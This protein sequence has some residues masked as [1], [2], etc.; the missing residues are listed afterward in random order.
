M[1][2]DST[3]QLC[4][5][6]LAIILGVVPLAI[7]LQIDA[8]EEA[9]LVRRLIDPRNRRST[10]VNLTAEGSTVRKQLRDERVRAAGQVFAADPGAAPDPART[11]QDGRAGPIRSCCPGR[12]G[13]RPRYRAT[14]RVAASP[15]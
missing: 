2:A 10:L 12:V 14:R 9:G 15:A 3:R 7:A 13:Q 5:G 6:D 11:A 4:I 8:L 1:L